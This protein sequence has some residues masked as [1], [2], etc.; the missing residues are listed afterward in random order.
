MS[1]LIRRSIPSLLLLAAGA[2]HGQVLCDI[3]K[4]GGG[5]SFYVK[6]TPTEVCPKKMTA[7]E[8]VYAVVECFQTAWYA[9]CDAWPMVYPGQGSGDQLQ[10]TWRVTRGGVT[11]VYPESSNASL[12]ISCPPMQNTLVQV[13]VR[14]GTASDTDS[15]GFRCGDDPY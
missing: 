15:V 1:A 9:N 13:T 8:P 10:Y 11:T 3:P 14:N 5:E 4:S 12:G 6:T 7:N 2:S